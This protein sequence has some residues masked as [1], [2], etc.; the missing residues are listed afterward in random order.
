MLAVAFRR[1]ALIAVLAVTGVVV[2]NAVNRSLGADVVVACAA[3]ALVCLLP[4]VFAWGIRSY[5][6]AVG[7]L[8]ALLTLASV[9]AAFGGSP[10]LL[11]A[12]VAS[13]LALVPTRRPASD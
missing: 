3:L 9:R 2:Q 1:Q 8:A 4:V 11:P 12:A 7:L 10:D 5:R 6:I 13:W